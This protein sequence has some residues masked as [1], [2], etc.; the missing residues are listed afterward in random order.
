M[1]IPRPLA[2]NEALAIEEMVHRSALALKISGGTRRG[3]RP[4]KQLPWSWGNHQHRSFWNLRRS[5][6]PT[7][8][9][10]QAASASPTW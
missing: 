5:L 7:R 2:T 8:R 1:G 10:G 3:K 6:F 4:A 9:T